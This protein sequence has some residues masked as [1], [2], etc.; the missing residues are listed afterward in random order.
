[1]DV[2][3]TEQQLPATSSGIQTGIPARADTATIASGSGS[4]DPLVRGR[5]ARRDPFDSGATRFMTG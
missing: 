4:S 2:Q 5:A 1:L 3:G